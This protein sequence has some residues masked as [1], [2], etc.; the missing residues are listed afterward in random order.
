MIVISIDFLRYDRA[1]PFRKWWEGTEYTQH[2]TH[3]TMTLPT[4]R[5]LVNKLSI[6]AR[7]SFATDWDK[8]MP[9]VKRQ[10]TSTIFRRGTSDLLA[11][12]YEHQDEEL[13]WVHLWERLHTIP[14]DDLTIPLYAKEY[15]QA[16][17]EL[18]DVIQ[19]F[20]KKVSCPLAITADHGIIIEELGWMGDPLYTRRDLCE[21]TLHVPLFMPGKKETITRRTSHDGLGAIFNGTSTEDWNV[22]KCWFMEDAYL[23]DGVNRPVPAP[24]PE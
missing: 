22:L 17:Q 20:A 5:R 10:F 11:Y 19:E 9:V 12:A 8:L 2:H 3:N 18:S 13:M 1:A 7:S 15:D 21:G 14:I 23:Y 24:I 6:P 4:F 16:I